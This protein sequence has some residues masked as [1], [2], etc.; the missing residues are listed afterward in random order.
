[1][2]S[3]LIFI[4]VFVVMVITSC[5]STDNRFTIINETNRPLFYTTSAYDTIEGNSPVQKFVEI[6][7][8]DTSWIESDYFVKPHGEKKKMVMS[9]WEDIVRN[10]F[11]GHI[12][13][14][15]FDADTLKK[16]NWNDVKVSN[17]Y[18]KKYEYTVDKL[19]GINWK[20][21]VKN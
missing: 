6:S 2:K 4:I 14:F 8:N 5:D 7:N 12:R 11:G 16:Y 9:N 1:M 10:N 21:K 3:F 20:I 18:F 15:I 13:V 17:R 19:K